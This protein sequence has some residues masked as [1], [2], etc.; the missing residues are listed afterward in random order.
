MKGGGGRDYARNPLLHDPTPDRRPARMPRGMR[1]PAAGLWVASQ[2]AQSRGR[3][4]A[5]V[6]CVETCRAPR[7]LPPCFM[8][9]S[10]S[11]SRSALA[12]GGVP[13]SALSSRGW[14]LTGTAPSLGFR[15]GAPLGNI[16]LIGMR[17]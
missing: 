2:P 14:A 1:M 12:S 4:A 3:A 13:A 5:A 8:P 11:T 7:C 10:C 17:F 6:L 9:R 15:R 16:G